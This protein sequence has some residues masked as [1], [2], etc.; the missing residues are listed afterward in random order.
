MTC[1]AVPTVIS[2]G[3]QILVGLATHGVKATRVD[4]TCSNLLVL[5][6]TNLR[7]SFSFILTGQWLNPNLRVFEYKK[8]DLITIQELAART[9]AIAGLPVQEEKRMLWR[10]LNALKPERPMVI[11]DQVCRNEMKIGDEFTLRCDDPDCC[12]Y[13]EI[14]RRTLFQW[15]HFPVDMV[16]EPFVRIPMAINNTGFG[17]DVEEEIAL[18][19]A[20]TRWCP[21]AT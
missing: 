4:L 17:I 19:D 1:L 11:V 3:G 15:N 14:L 16:V 8:S 7:S 2:I 12:Y 13:E 18:M 21:T 10:S 20:T 5:K 9:A 6:S